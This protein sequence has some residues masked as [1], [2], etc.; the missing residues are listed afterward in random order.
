MVAGHHDPC[1]CPIQDSRFC[2]LEVLP[3]YHDPY[4]LLETSVADACELVHSQR[5]AAHLVSYNLAMP[6]VYETERLLRFGDY[7]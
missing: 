7:Y 4:L 2:V 1:P 6:A 3:I 5:L